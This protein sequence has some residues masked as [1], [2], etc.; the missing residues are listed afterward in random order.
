M[1]MT[2]KVYRKGN[3]MKFLMPTDEPEPDWEYMFDIEHDPWTWVGAGEIADKLH[4][5]EA[6]AEMKERSPPYFG[7]RIIIDGH[8]G[9]VEKWSG[10]MIFVPDDRSFTIPITP[11]TNYTPVDGMAVILFN[12]PPRT[13]IRKVDFAW[14]DHIRLWYKDGRVEE[15]H[16]GDVYEVVI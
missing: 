10:T 6:E 15:V 2:W 12:E 8:I 11:Y 13:G 9:T 4:K 16:I 7:D 1:T 3:E 14:A 5:L